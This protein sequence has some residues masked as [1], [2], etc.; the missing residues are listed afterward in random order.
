MSVTAR[1][2]R[3]RPKL[4]EAGAKRA[5]V[6]GTLRV[7]LVEDSEDDAMLLLRELRR[8]GYEPLSQRVCTPEDM[9]KALHAADEGD[10]PF[11]VVIS[12]YY[13]PRFRAPDALRLLR[14]LGYDLPF[15]VVSGRIGEDVAVE[16]MRAGAYDYVMKDNL[17]RLCPTMERGLDEAEER[18]ERRRTEEELCRRDAILDAV[19]FASDQF[20][21]EA[22]GWEESVRAVLWRLGEAAKASRVYIFENFA[23]EDGEVWATQ[24]YEWVAAEVP[25]QR[26]VGQLSDLP[27]HLDPGRPRPDDDKGQPL[28]GLLR[29]GAQL[30]KLE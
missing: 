12:D 5:P 11:Q 13:M 19:R 21:G 7:L 14:E 8:G 15:I 22:A 6:T 18:R 17:A 25:A 26:A 28:L 29:V 23:D 27:S 1:S 3:R 2:L 24:R 16:T 30:G 20:L 9:E 4:R 10:E